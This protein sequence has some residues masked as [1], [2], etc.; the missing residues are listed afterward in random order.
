MADAGMPFRQTGKPSS[1]FDV[2]RALLG[3]S[4][5]PFGMETLTKA[6]KRQGEASD[7]LSEEDGLD[8]LLRFW[9]YPPPLPSLY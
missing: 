8:G 1:Q 7:Q 2:L 3:A 6:M 9:G 4:C 5:N